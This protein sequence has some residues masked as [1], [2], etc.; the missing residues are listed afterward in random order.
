MQSIGDLVTVADVDTVVRLDAADGLLGQL[1]LTGDVRSGIEEV[2]QAASGSFGAAFFVVGPFGSGKSHFLAAAAELLSGSTPPPELAQVAASARRSLAVR[3]PLVEYRSGAALEDVVKARAWRALGEA[4]PA[5]GT[6]RAAHWDSFLRAAAD[7]GWDGIVLLVDELSEML[8]AKRGPQ[9]TEDLRFLQFLGEWARGHP[10]VVLAALQESLDEAVNVSELELARIRDRYRDSLRLSMRH[11]EDLVRGRLV[12]LRPGAEALVAE[13]YRDLSGAFPAA[14]VDAERFGR[15][16]PLHPETLSVLEGLRFLLSE[17]R[18]VVAFAC[19]QVRADL[20]RPYT[21]LV[22]PDRIF[23]HFLER[24]RERRETARLAEVVVPYYERAV[25]EMFGEDDRDLALRTVKLLCVLSASPLERPRTAAELAGMLLEKVSATE[26]AANV[27]YLEKAVLAPLV[28]RGAYVVATAGSPPAYRIEPGADAAVVLRSRIDQARA[29]LHEADRRMVWTLVELGST[30][31]L[32]LALMGQ[33]G[34]ARREVFWQNTLRSVLAGVARVVDLGPGDAADLVGRARSAGAD[35]V[36]VVGELEL[37][38]GAADALDAARGLVSSARRIGIWVPAPLGADEAEVLAELHARRTVG[39]VAAREGRPDLLDA[40]ERA[41]AEGR[42]RAREILA[43]AYFSGT[44]VADGEPVDMAPLA[45]TSFEGQLPFLVGAV[46]SGLHPEHAEVAPRAEL[47]GESVLRRLATEVIPA[48]RLGGMALDRGGLR[49]LAEAFLVPLGLAR[50]RRDG[51]VVSPEPGRSRPVAAVLGLV[52]ESETVR[53]PDVVAALADGPL[54]LTEAESLLVLNACAQAGLVELWRGRSRNRQPLLAVTGADRVSPGELVG[55]AVR[56]TVAALSPAVTGPGPFEPWSSSTQRSAWGYARAWLEGQRENAAQVRQGIAGLADSPGLAGAD[57][58]GAGAD[59]AVIDAVVEVC[60][61]E[62]VPAAGLSTLAAACDRAP[63]ATAG[64]QQAP[65]MELGLV[66]P[67]DPPGALEGLVVAGRRLGALARF[68]RDDIGQLAAAAAYLAHPDLVLPEGEERLRTLRAEALQGLGAVLHLAAEGRLGEWAAL[69]RE[70]RSAYLAAYQVAH[71]RHYGAV[72]RADIEAVRS[73]PAYRALCALAAVGAASVPDDRIKVDRMLGAAAPVPCKRAVE[74]DLAWGPRCTCGFT[75][76][77][78]P[79]V[80]DSAAVV[81]T[82]ARGV[83][84]HLAELGSAPNA[85]K[86]EDA[87]GDLDA[88]G[89]ETAAAALREL[90]AMAAAPA[91]A[92]LGRITEIVSPEVQGV[93][94]EALGGARLIVSRDLTTLR[95][96]LIGRRY[97]KARLLEHLAAWVDP[98]GSLPADGVVEVT[99]S[100]ES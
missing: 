70:F 6:D 33:V 1:V 24:L 9:L 26:P 84:Q 54:G 52:G 8:K 39:E 49:H 35:A 78:P 62:T 83:A 79:P 10:V 81:A 13:A 88:L 23:D 28:A 77:M 57:T 86:L 44:L 48:G 51:L 63:G 80:L 31:K 42:A 27:A 19:Q 61:E 66:A 69:N 36:V 82:A 90:V 34:F 53:A 60:A 12:R 100:A 73:S 92:D 29:E 32:P 97:P 58:A 99:D 16:Y 38:A 5:G 21:R 3:V 15:C 87:A 50:V 85:G 46:L 4:E 64:E 47:V 59:L 22:T 45:G 94:R 76:A 56:R 43:R 75:M 37:G 40:L 11:V 41:E 7:G 18:G 71:E 96:D 93:L 68:F 25:A 2:A 67:G 72:T 30:D 89:R 17:Q 74:R 14:R 20:G 98:D 91:R 55:A 95:E 65:A